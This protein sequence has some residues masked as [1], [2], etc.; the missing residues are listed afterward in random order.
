ML[1]DDA[2]PE[3]AKEL[4]ARIVEAIHEIA[5]NSDA[6]DV[7]GCEREGC[8]KPV[9]P[10]YRSFDD[11]D[12]IDE[13]ADD[14]EE[15]VCH[16]H[17]D[18]DDDDLRYE[19]NGEYLTIDQLVTRVDLAFERLAASKPAALC[20]DGCHKIYS[21]RNDAEIAHMR[22]LGYQHFVFAG[23]GRKHSQDEM[24]KVVRGWYHESCELVFISGLEPEW[25]Q[26]IPQVFA[27]VVDENDPGQD[28]AE[29][30]DRIV[31]VEF[32]GEGTAP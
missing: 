1:E 6:G 2:S 28:I 5:L 23:N 20:Y 24:M 19:W 4:S 26:Y 11:I 31:E 32:A 14:G 9:V 25:E 7:Y 30:F 12:G 16:R 22:S 21:L 3:A 8:G 10:V 27:K 18:D 29:A 13:D 17:E 15:Y